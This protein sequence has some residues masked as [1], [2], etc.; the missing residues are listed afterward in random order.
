MIAA[1]ASLLPPSTTLRAYGSTF[2]GSAGAAVS[3]Y[4]YCW[5]TSAPAMSADQIPPASAASGTRL[6]PPPGCASETAAALAS[7]AHTRKVTPPGKGVDPM[8]GRS[9]GAVTTIDPPENLHRI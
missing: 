8:P 7:G 9:D 4:W 3:T 5:P 6:A 2:G 1:F